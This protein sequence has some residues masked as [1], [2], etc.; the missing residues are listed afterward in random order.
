MAVKTEMTVIY[1]QDNILADNTI[2]LSIV[3][4][5]FTQ[6]AQSFYFSDRPRMSKI[7]GIERM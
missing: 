5:E 4:L 2:R 7:P 3:H 6:N 1:S